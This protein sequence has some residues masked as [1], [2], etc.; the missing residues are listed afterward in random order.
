MLTTVRNVP[1]LHSCA[2]ITHCCVFMATLSGFILLT[3]VS[4]STTIQRESS[5]VFPWQQWLR[6]HATLHV[7]CLSCLMSLILLR[8]AG[9]YPRNLFCPSFHRHIHW[10][11]FVYDKWAP[12]ITAWD[13]LRLRME[14]RPPIWRVA[15]NILNKQ[16]RTADKGWSSSLGLG[17]VL[18]T[19][20]TKICYETDTCASGLD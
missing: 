20:Y 19:P 3:T 13:F 8:T 4:R 7:Y 10:L 17:E 1:Q 2:R 9:C 6:E 12:V 14:E 5:V 16:S 18:T 11:T 15:A